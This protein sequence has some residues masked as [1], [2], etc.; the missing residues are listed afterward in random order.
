MAVMQKRTIKHQIVQSLTLQVIRKMLNKSSTFRSLGRT[1]CQTPRSIRFALARTRETIYT[2]RMPARILVKLNILIENVKRRAYIRRGFIE[3]IKRAVVSK[4]SIIVIVYIV[5]S[6]IATDRT[7]RIYDNTC[8][9]VCVY[10]SKIIII[11]PHAAH[12]P[13]L[14]CPLH[15]RPRI[16]GVGREGNN[17]MLSGPS[18]GILYV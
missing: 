7:M 1:Q 12:S 16:P 14:S 17:V 5:V 18:R 2:T 13:S 11:T 3:E 15:R 9:R 4:G 6:R 10:P 8:V